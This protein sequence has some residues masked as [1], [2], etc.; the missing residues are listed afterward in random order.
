MGVKGVSEKTR[1]CKESKSTDGI[2]ED[3]LNQGRFGS[4]NELCG[5]IPY[6]K[7]QKFGLPVA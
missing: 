5:C 2:L 1:D 6:T 4:H 3:D 7:G